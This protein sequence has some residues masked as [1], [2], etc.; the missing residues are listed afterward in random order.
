[1]R[2]Q[3]FKKLYMKLPNIL[4]TRDLFVIY[5][6]YLLIFLRIKFFTNIATKSY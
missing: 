2:V 1:M 5:F 3:L 6:L 4:F